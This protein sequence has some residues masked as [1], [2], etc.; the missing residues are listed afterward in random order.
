MVRFISFEP[1]IGPVG[2]VDL[3]GIHWSIVGGESGPGARIMRGPWVDE[4]RAACAD[5]SIAFFFKQWGGVNK[6]AAG[7][8]YQGRT[9]EEFQ[10]QQ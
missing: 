7:R 1:L 6:K 3:T 2:E 5:Q 9:W 4:I 8:R 10:I